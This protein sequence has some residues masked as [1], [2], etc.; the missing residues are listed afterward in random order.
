MLNRYLYSSVIFSAYHGLKRDRVNR[1]RADLKASEWLPRNDLVELQKDK[2]TRL[3]RFARQHVPYYSRLIEQ[4]GLTPDVLARPEYFRMLPVL[5][6]SVIS[7]NT[8]DMVS[9]SLE[10]NS[11]I[12]NSTS[13]STGTALRF[14]TDHRSMDYRLAT[15]IR[16]QE[17]L[18][19]QLHDRQVKLWGSPIDSRKNMGWKGRAR[20]LITGVTLFSAYEMSEKRMGEYVKKIQKIKPVLLTAYPSALEVFAGYCQKNDVLIPTLKAI[21]LSAE[22]LWDYQREH[23]TNV[24][25]APTYNRYGCR[26]VGD[27]AHECPEHS[28]LHVNTERIYLELVDEAGRPCEPGEKGEILVTDLD[29][30]GMPFIRYRMGDFGTWVEDASTC[31]CGR[32]HPRLASV[33]GRTM[34]VVE[35]ANGA[36]IGGTFWTILLRSRVGVRK[37]QVV[38]RESNSVDISIVPEPGLRQET[39][40]YYTGKIRE[41]CGSEFKINFRQVE[42][43]KASSTGKQRYII[44]KLK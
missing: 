12:K 43:I 44:N 4:T 19:V 39:L 30:Y 11:L 34:D 36:K 23:F 10:G 29:N 6:K 24:F 9:S 18:G 41:K 15:V 17:W 40:D 7:D 16:N 22:T 1:A 8:A 2:L 3:L 33:E 31:S 27:I 26:E 20:E 37:F 5:T 42:D 14:Y 13:G 32:S 38:Q 25:R 28:G 21:L 35:G